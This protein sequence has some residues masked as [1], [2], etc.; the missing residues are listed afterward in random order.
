MS[1]YKLLDDSHFSTGNTTLN[2][3]IFNANSLPDW[4]Y[5]WYIFEKLNGH[6]IY[7]YQG[8]WKDY[9]GTEFLINAFIP[10]EKN[11]YILIYKNTQ[12]SD[13]YIK[14]V[15]SK[16]RLRDIENLEEDISEEIGRRL[17]YGTTKNN[18]GVVKLDYSL[19]DVKTLIDDLNK[20]ITPKEINF[21]YKLVHY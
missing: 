20:F 18:Q 14:A 12:T 3:P 4:N 6:H 16:E 13:I 8:S 10:S 17:M 19:P 2:I 5:I 7:K 11:R 1:K 9:D 21:S 15:S